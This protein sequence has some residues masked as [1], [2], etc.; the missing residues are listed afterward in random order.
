MKSLVGYTN[1]DDEMEPPP[2][3]TATVE[4]TI[5]KKNKRPLV[6]ISAAPEIPV[7]DLLE[8][9]SAVAVVARAGSDLTV[10][11]NLTFQEMYRPVQ[12]IFIP[13]LP[14]SRGFP[15]PGLNIP[16]FNYPRDKKS[17]RLKK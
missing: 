5:T 16:G 4:M 7:E 6:E 12:G 14:R 10:A 2:S 17:P 3:K 1:S 13:S 15:L 9:V 11:A 8:N